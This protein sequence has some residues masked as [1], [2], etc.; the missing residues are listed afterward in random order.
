MGAVVIEKKEFP[1]LIGGEWVRTCS[2]RIITLPFDGT[3]VGEVY[4]A[5]AATAERAVAAAH[6]GAAVVA[7][8]TQYERA[9]LLDRM[10]RLLERDASEFALL[11]SCESGK[12]IRE[13]RLE[14]DRSVQTLLASADAARHLQGE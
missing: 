5:D 3:P 9:E 10:R 11:I 6:A 14:V 2:P 4:D 1:M 12:P 13:G 7:R 8:L